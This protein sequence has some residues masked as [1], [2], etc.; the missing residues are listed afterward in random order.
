MYCDDYTNDQTK[1]KN[2]KTAKYRRWQNDSC[3]IDFVRLVCVYIK[4]ATGNDK[5][6]WEEGA[7]RM[8]SFIHSLLLSKKMQSLRMQYQ[9]NLPD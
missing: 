3:C 6:K 2:K 1:K 4:D 8:N 9:V 7:Y 5:E